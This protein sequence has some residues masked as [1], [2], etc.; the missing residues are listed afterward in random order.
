MLHTYEVVPRRS[1]GPVHFGMSRAEARAAMGREPER[2]FL[3]RPQYPVEVDSYHEGTFRIFYDGDVPNVN[4]IELSAKG[5]V[6]AVFR[7]IQVFETKASELVDVVS[8]T[9]QYDDQHPE[10]GYSYIFPSL[11]IAFW[12]PMLPEDEPECEFFQAVGAGTEGYYAKR[13]T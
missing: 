8:K 6:D 3:K 7:G 10:L 13:V 12:R 11:D 2:S 9:D 4:Y 1:V 5:E